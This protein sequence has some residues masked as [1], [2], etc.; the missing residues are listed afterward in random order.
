MKPME[1]NNK[2]GCHTCFEANKRLE[3]KKKAINVIKPEIAA[4]NLIENSLNFPKSIPEILISQNGNRGFV[5]C[6]SKL[7]VGTN[8]FLRRYISLAA[9]AHLPSTPKSGRI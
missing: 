3:R 1:V 7:I 5:K 9:S 4:G 8:Q 6:G 2:Y